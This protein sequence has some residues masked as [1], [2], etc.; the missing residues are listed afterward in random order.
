MLQIFTGKVPY[1]DTPDFQIPNTVQKK[2]IR[3]KLPP[4]IEGTTTVGKLMVE[5]WDARPDSR[6]S[7]ARI[8]DDLKKAPAAPD[9][10]GQFGIIS[11][12]S[13]RCL[14]APS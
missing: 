5:C 10:Y 6:P 8:Q 11:R 3:P 9:S 7:F 2:K 4:G 14:T 13:Y 1:A 12:I